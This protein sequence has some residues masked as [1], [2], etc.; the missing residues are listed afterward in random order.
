MS[1]FSDLGGILSSVKDVTDEIASVKDDL[2]SS[3]TESIKTITDTK[4]EIITEAQTIADSA[5]DK[6]K[7]IDGIKKPTSGDDQP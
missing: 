2:V 3:A 4:D 5:K 6:I 1:L 7:S